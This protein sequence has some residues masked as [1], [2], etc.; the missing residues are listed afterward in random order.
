VD[1][2]VLPGAQPGQSLVTETQKVRIRS[3]AERTRYE[4]FSC[5][6]RSSEKTRAN[7]DG[8]WDEE[9]SGDEV[10]EPWMFE[11]ARVY[12]KS[13]MLLAE[14]DPEVEAEGMEFNCA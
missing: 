13:L 2:L 9:D 3:L 6:G 11:A 5:L 7:G 14:Q 1:G 8:A 12:E 4:V 10:D